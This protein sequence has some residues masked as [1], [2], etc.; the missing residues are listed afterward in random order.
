MK[1][2]L[3]VAIGATLFTLGAFGIASAHATLDH[4]T[5]AVDSTVATAPN[6]H[7]EDLIR[8]NQTYI[9]SR[10]IRTTIPSKY[11]RSPG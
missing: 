8:A 11:Y 5:P 10:A 4:C 3:L 9:Y 2:M 6:R 1:R 7:I